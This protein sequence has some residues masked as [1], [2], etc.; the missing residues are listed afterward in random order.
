MLFD[1]HCHV[2]FAA[3]NHDRDEVLKRNLEKGVVMN[4]V[5]TQKDTSEAAVKLAE[6]Y[7]NVYASIATHPVHLHSTH[8]DEEESSFL[9]REEDFNEAF[10]ETLVDSKKVIAIGETGLD[11]FHLPKDIPTATVLEKQTAV[12]LKHVRFALKHNLPLV[13]HCRE[14]HDEMIK[15]LIEEK[16]T[17]GEKLRGTIHC[18]TSHLDHAHAYLDLGF[19]LGFT[20][21]ITFA[22]KK[23]DPKAQEN[24]LQVVKEMPLERMLVETDAPYLSPQAYRGKRGEPYMVEEQIGFIATLRG[25]EEKTVENQIF[26]NTQALFLPLK[27]ESREP[28]ITFEQL[29]PER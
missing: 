4:V 13:I 12:F 23:T 1:T 16:K 26:E 27:P 2:Q 17:A 18:F 29:R 15:I 7:D 19:H 10:Y 14:A 21:V 9:S 3:Y 6:Q 24:L 28:G 25:I 11:A 22:P 8:I 20:G 5:G